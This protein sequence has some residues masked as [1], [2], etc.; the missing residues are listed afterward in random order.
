MIREAEAPSGKPEGHQLRVR[1][2]CFCH[3]RSSRP[4]SQYAQVVLERS[5][6]QE[7]T[8]TLFRKYQIA[9][10]KDPP[11]KLSPQKYKQFLVDTPLQFENPKTPNAPG[12]GSFHQKYYTNDNKLIA[13]GVIDILPYCVSSVYFMYDPD[14]AFLSLGTYSALREI[15][16]TMLLEETLPELK[17]YYMG[18]LGL[19]APVPQRPITL[20]IL[21]YYI[22]S[23]EKMRYKAHYRPS[24]L[25]CPVGA[26]HAFV[27]IGGLKANCCLFP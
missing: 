11:T 20:S 21:G 26:Y 4:T 12:Y 6:Y 10:H 15:G 17:Y 24:S 7:E 2:P 22:H 9:I 14:Y 16:F 8:Y 3:L 19:V 13:V 27:F 25:L 23:C 5:S 1:P 18:G